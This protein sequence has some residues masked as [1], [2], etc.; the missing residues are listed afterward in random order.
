[1]TA[2]YLK[3][4]FT[5]HIT[6]KLYPN[7]LVLDLDVNQIKDYIIKKHDTQEL[8]G[9]DGRYH[10]DFFKDDVD[11]YTKILDLVETVS[12]R[13]ASGVRKLVLPDSETR[14]AY[15]IFSKSNDSPINHLESSWFG[16][17]V[18]LTRELRLVSRYNEIDTEV[19]MTKGNFIV[20]SKKF[21]FACKDN[22]NGEGNIYLL[23]VYER[24]DNSSLQSKVKY[25]F[26]VDYWEG[27][28]VKKKLKVD[29]IKEKTEHVPLTSDNNSHIENDWDSDSKFIVTELIVESIA[30]DIYNIICDVRAEELRKRKLSAFAEK[31]VIV[32]NHLLNLNCRN[33]NTTGENLATGIIN[34]GSH[35]YINSV[36]QLL[37]R[38]SLIHIYQSKFSESTSNSLLSEFFVT[39]ELLRNRNISFIYIRDFLINLLNDN[40]FC[41][42][43]FGCNVHDRNGLHGSS[44]EFLKFIFSI[45]NFHISCPNSTIEYIRRDD[46]KEECQCCKNGM[47][48]RIDK[49]N[50]VVQ[51]TLPRLLDVWKTPDDKV[52]LGNLLLSQFSLEKQVFICEETK[53]GLESDMRLRIFGDS[54]LISIERTMSDGHNDIKLKHTIDIDETLHYSGNNYYLQ[55]FIVHIGKGSRSGHYI[56]YSRAS[57]NNWIKVNDE[58]VNLQEANIFNKIYIQENITDLLY[59]VIKQNI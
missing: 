56:S 53:I 15:F 11:F 24:L 10:F 57:D 9:L 34:F 33:N 50:P 45:L 16:Y 23:V 25:Q 51:I 46:G 7:I 36:L 52:S 32:V 20:A 5:K 27:R 58:K 39:L 8:R 26:L 18:C 14:S 55:A 38:C 31:S 35:C 22:G 47:L 19:I 37:S 3:D 12:E 49:S 1:M 4:T 6:Y 54:L 40:R 2:K 13:I 41:L 28:R 43:D 44:S 59:E 30:Y 21:C 48:K 29:K 42:F 17:L